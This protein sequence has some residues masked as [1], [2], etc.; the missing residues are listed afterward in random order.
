MTEPHKPARRRW[1]RWAVIIVVLLLVA[2]AVLVLTGGGGPFKY[3]T[4]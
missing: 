1:V 4:F 3:D 2:W